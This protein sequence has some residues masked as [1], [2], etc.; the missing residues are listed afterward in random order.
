MVLLI[1]K[2]GTIQN[3]MAF[4]KNKPQINYIYR[5]WFGITYVVLFNGFVFTMGS[6]MQ[7]Y[8]FL[9]FTLCVWQDS[10]GCQLKEPQNQRKV[11]LHCC[12][13]H[14]HR[15][16]VLKHRVTRGLGSSAIQ[17]S[18]AWQW[19]LYDTWAEAGMGIYQ[20]HH[21]SAYSK[22]LFTNFMNIVSPKG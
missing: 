10:L 14:P 13:P 4:S 15:V 16:D 3:L 21:D 12:N 5:V 9:E 18:A 2:T 17:E 11:L 22:K 7:N 8:F 19:Q 6:N 20:Y 1:P